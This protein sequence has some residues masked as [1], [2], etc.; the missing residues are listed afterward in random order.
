MPNHVLATS[1]SL[2]LPRDQV[3]EFFAHAGNLGRI[4]PPELDFRIV[5]PL[6]IEM[7][8]GALIDYTIGLFGVP[9]RWRTLITRWDP[10]HAF[11]DRQ[12]R[13]PYALW[14]HTH[15]FREIEGGTAIDDRVEYRL[16]LSPLGDLALPLVRLQLGRIFSHRQRAVRELLMPRSG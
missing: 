6:P 4:T 11:E 8:E 1:M 7:R 15:T 13:G 12:L 16:P 2:P 5:T 3:F 9:M 10:P 14:L